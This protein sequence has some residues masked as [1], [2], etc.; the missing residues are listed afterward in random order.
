M[1]KKSRTS[2]RQS[3]HDARGR[4]ERLLQR[5]FRKPY[6]GIFVILDGQDVILT[7]NN[8]PTPQNMYS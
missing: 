7:L 2:S 6:L 5:E 4:T 8:R 3:K 1:Y